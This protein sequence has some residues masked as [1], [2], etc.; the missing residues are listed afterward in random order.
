MEIP[1]PAVA[2]TQMEPKDFFA[3]KTK[4][5]LG[6][7]LICAGMGGIDVH[8]Q[9]GDGIQKT[10]QSFP[11]APDQIFQGNSNL[12]AAADLNQIRKNGIIQ[13]V[14]RKRM[15]DADSDFQMFQH[16]SQKLKSPD[17]FF[18]RQIGMNPGCMAL[19]EWHKWGQ[20][21]PGTVRKG[22][23]GVTFTKFGAFK[24]CLP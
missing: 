24:P 22:P 7:F 4:E 12:M 15:K 5:F 17:N 21:F 2:V 16:E 10:S 20:A 8:S 14:V 19:C 18:F 13:T 3:E 9:S 6:S 23:G 11:L 1:G